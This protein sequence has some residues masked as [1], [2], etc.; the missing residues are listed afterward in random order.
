MRIKSE[1]QQRVEVFMR[2][3]G[4]LMPSTPTIPSEHVRLLRARL[5]LEEAMETIKALGVTVKVK[6]L[7]I[8]DISGCVP[9][10]LA[11]LKVENVPLDLVEIADGFADVSVVNVGGMLA[12]GI[13]DV[14]LLAEVDNNNLA[15]LRHGRVDEGG[16]FI[17]PPSHPAPNISRVLYEQGGVALQQGARGAAN[18]EV[19][20]GTA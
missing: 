6:L 19:A 10:E 17:K 2:G 14:G 11:G 20:G 16:K 13:S 5:L 7:P 12:C 9:F 3:A 1:H 15:K 18:P 4:Q 8:K